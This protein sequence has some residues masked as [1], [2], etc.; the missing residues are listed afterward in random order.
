MGLAAPVLVRCWCGCWC[1][2]RI[3][4]RGG[5]GVRFGHGVRLGR[6]FRS[7][8]SACQ[9]RNV[10][11][12]QRGIVDRDVRDF[13]VERVAVI[14]RP[15]PAPDTQRAEMRGLGAGGLGVG[16][17]HAVGFL[18]VNVKRDLVAVE[19][20]GDMGLIARL[21]AVE[22]QHLGLVLAFDLDPQR[23]AGQEDRHVLGVAAVEDGVA[24]IK[25]LH[26]RQGC[27]FE[28][29]RQGAL[30]H[31]ERI[32][33]RKRQDICTMAVDPDRVLLVEHGVHAKKR[34][35]HRCLPRIKSTSGRM[36][37][38][39]GHSGLGTGVEG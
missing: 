19:G 16:G 37:G 13:A 33:V 11:R 27:C 7:R 28:A 4:I 22:I 32:A 38:V 14:L 1:G 17:C 10:V 6:G 23:R 39:P 29:E 35:A 5:H 31:I 2:D 26:R 20:D 18:A 36:S 21:H 3:R 15:R 12:C 30:G 25:P 9:G 8:G 34:L 24:G